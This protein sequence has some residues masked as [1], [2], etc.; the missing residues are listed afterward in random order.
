[1]ELQEILD[2]IAHK[3]VDHGT[4]TETASLHTLASAA[5]QIAP[6]ASQALTD[7]DGSEIARLR[8]YGTIA[9]VLVR[10]TSTVAQQDLAVRLI[11]SED[12][13]VAA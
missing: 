8:A 5:S 12:L 10:D 3:I 1:M 11:G 7:W 2:T 4:T 9:R 6:G 13:L